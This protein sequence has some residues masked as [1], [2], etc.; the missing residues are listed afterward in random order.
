MPSS[1]IHSTSLDNL[2]L[3]TGGA[4]SG[5]S[6]LAENLAGS[7]VENTDGGGKVA[8]LATMPRLESDAELAERIKRHQDRRPANWQTIEAPLSIHEQIEKLPGEIRVCIIDCLS[9]YVSNLIFDNDRDIEAIVQ[10][11][12][13]FSQIEKKL[14]YNLDLLLAGIN[15]K[16]NV[17]FIVVTNEVGWSVVPENRLARQ[18]RDLLGTANQR[19]SR[20]ADTVYL[21]VSGIELKIKDNGRAILSERS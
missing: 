20:E 11:E 10:T 2:M 6:S 21:C 5:K 8:Y 16:R 7:F 18:Y 4:R 3:V 17:T 1:K 15:S 19:V 9:V 14:E 13:D 12:I